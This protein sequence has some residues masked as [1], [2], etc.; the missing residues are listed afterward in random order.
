MPVDNNRWVY[1]PDGSRQRRGRENRE[2]RDAVIVHRERTAVRAEAAIRA[3]TPAAEELAVAL[4]VDPRDVIGT[5]L[6]GKITK[7]D[8]EAAAGD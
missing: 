8:V 2:S 6:N 3:I 7:G 1:L 5:G 4:G